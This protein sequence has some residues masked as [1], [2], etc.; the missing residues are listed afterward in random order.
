MK[1][2]YK[3]TEIGIIPEDWDLVQLE[4]MCMKDGLIRGPFGSALKKEFFV[5]HGIKVL[6]QKNAINQSV[7]LG[8]YYIAQER[9]NFLRRFE[10]KNG[11]VI[12]SCSGTIGAA[13]ILPELEYTCIINQALLLIRL[14]KN[15][16]SS[17]FFYYLFTWDRTQSRITDSTQ[18]GAMK[19]LVGM[20]IF[21]KTVFA[22]P[23]KKE[24]TNIANSLSEI[25]HLITSLQ[26]LIKKKQLIKQGVMQELLT[27]K[28][29]L[30]G[31][32]GEWETKRLG[33][34]ASIDKGQQ[35]NSECF[36]G[37]GEYPVMNGGISPSGYTNDF[38][39]YGNTVVISEGGNSC[40]YVNY[41][42]D[43]FWQGG[44]CYSLA[45]SQCDLFLYYALKCKEKDIMS[46]RVGSGLPNV[47]I[48]CLSELPILVPSID[49]QFE[50]ASQLRD[51]DL[52]I[53]AQ[54]QRYAKLVLL[55][56]AMMQELLTGRIRLL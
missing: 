25:D 38:N 13:Y 30:P 51:F 46:L 49:E 27:G 41:M 19:N 35:L 52:D 4:T 17:S 20:D 8:T 40:G 44:H 2:G 31:F 56:Q 22:I 9:F 14:N 29:R 23:S 45:T 7:G 28:R 24:Q 26:K 12:V 11:D 39:A 43:R 15:I 3:L 33:E 34:I 1:P 16:V 18:G 47:Q 53:S 21:R 32:T 37:Y 36:V 54:K 10:A 6:E 55:K 48:S 42:K 5:N 50:I